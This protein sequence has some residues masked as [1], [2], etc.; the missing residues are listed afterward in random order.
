MAGMGEVN[1]DGLLRLGSRRLELVLAPALGGSIARLDLVWLEGRVPLLRGANGTPGNI[2]ETACFPLVPFANR[3]RGGRFTFRGRRVQLPPNLEDEPLPLHG[4]GLNAA[5]EITSACGHEAELIFRHAPGDWPWAYEA[6]QH[7]R[8]HE[9]ALELVLSCRN[10][11][12]APM[13]CGLGL[14]PFFQCDGA[15]RFDAQAAV[16]WTTD[17]D[18]LP[19]ARAPA[20]GRFDLRDRA[21][22]GAALDQCFEGWSGRAGVRPSAPVEIAIASDAAF[23]HVYAPA[24]KAVFAAEPVTHRPAAL[25]E[26]EDAWAEAGLRVLGPGEETSLTMRIEALAA[27]G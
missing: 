2:L 6:R 15:T 24:G 25:N 22:C 16:A 26:P 11:S 3:V 27:M 21:L 17:A 1:G 7:F 19:V 12:N 20:E 23:L 9:A 5:W 13:P 8:L 10:L 4:Q 14:H 18:T